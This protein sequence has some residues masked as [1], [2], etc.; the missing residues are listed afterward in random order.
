MSQITTFKGKTSVW[1][2]QVTPIV[3]RREILQLFHHVTYASY[4]LEGS[5]GLFSF[6]FWSTDFF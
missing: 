1:K 5:F 6:K 2:T 4:S 3:A